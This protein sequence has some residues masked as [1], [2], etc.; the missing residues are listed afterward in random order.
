MKTMDTVRTDEAL[1][2]EY[3]RTASPAALE[4]LVERHWPEA[5]RLALRVLGDSVAAEDTAQEALVWLVRVAKR[6]RPGAPFGPWF[7]TLVLNAARKTLRSRTRRRALEERVA[8][9]LASTR[10]PSEADRRELSA[11]VEERLYQLPEE[12]RSPI[13]LHFM[14]GH[15]HEEVAALVGCPTGT[16]SSR[17]RRGLEQ[18]RASMAR[19]GYAVS[20]VELGQWCTDHGRT[21]VVPP[22]AP[23]VALLEHQA[24]ALAKASLLVTLLV[25]AVAVALVTVGVVAWRGASTKPATEDGSKESAAIAPA[26]ESGQA[27]GAATSPRAAETAPIASDSREQDPPPPPPPPGSEAPERH[28]GDPRTGGAA[29]LRDPGLRVRVIGPDGARVASAA[30]ALRFESADDTRRDAA[31]MAALLDLQGRSKGNTFA[32]ATTGPDGEAWLPTRD[33]DGLPVARLAAAKTK[34]EIA[35]ALAVT[36]RRGLLGGSIAAPSGLG[37]SATAIEVRVA[38]PE[39][40]AEGCGSLVAKVLAPDGRPAAATAVRLVVLPVSYGSMLGIPE[41]ADY[42][43]ALDVETDEDG[44]IVLRDLV[45]DTYPLLFCAKDHAPARAR[46]VVKAGAVSEVSVRLGPAVRI[47]GHVRR[48]GGPLPASISVTCLDATADKAAR[49]TAE[50]MKVMGGLSDARAEIVPAS[51]GSYLVSGLVA[52]SYTLEAEA[53]GFGAVRVTVPVEQGEAIAPDLVLG[54]GAT[55]AGR[56]VSSRGVPL[57][58]ATV[59]LSRKR[60]PFAAVAT[61]ADGTFRLQGLPAG[62]ARLSVSVL[63]PSSP[64]GRILA[65]AG[66]RRRA[67]AVRGIAGATD[68]LEKTIT[69]PEGGTSELGDLVV[70]N[71]NGRVS[72]R[73]VGPD[74][75]PVESAAVTFAGALRIPGRIVTSGPDG[76]FEADLKAGHYAVRISHRSFALAGDVAVEV[77]ADQQVLLADLRV[78]RAATIHGSI[79]GPA[80]R[81]ARITGVV[82]LAADGSPA[83][84]S[85]VHRDGT[86]EIRG[87]APGEYRVSLIGV[88]SAPKAVTV[89]EGARER[90]DFAI[91]GRGEGRILVK[92]TTKDGVRSGFSAGVYTG[93]EIRGIPAATAKSAATDAHAEL[94]HLD[95]GSVTVLVS[96]DGDLGLVLFRSGLSVAAEAPL[97]VSFTLPDPA[98]SGTIEG[99]V[100]GAV[101]RDQVVAIGDGVAVI[102]AQRS[103]GTFTLENVPAGTYRVGPTS[104]GFALVSEHSVTVTVEAGKT[105]AAAIR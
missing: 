5:F 96:P 71:A 92:V 99:T 13:V 77:A 10:R 16:A 3:A 37:E 62:K 73:V 82:A 100:A 57:A 48:E 19:A 89:R 56:V 90:A 52:G 67:A 98:G 84:N 72:G 2:L 80:S 15:S 53:P 74:G 36:A 12:L 97:E 44:C 31:P 87:L 25:P 103:D 88:A 79:S 86:Y 6:F 75:A 49:G 4:E 29:S 102:G 30:V 35:H 18:M 94:A 46:A 61:E 59:T 39:K 7:R 23:S 34:V 101:A 21:A 20:A 24:A 65:E 9:R 43:V 11:D 26:E 17:I 104:S 22:A 8:A 50:M 51:D 78:V 63:E 32:S 64:M 68:A 60:E 45:P 76:R 95:V 33:P 91:A 54:R 28:P 85:F 69:L 58:S 38:G 40:T 41:D 14:E 81:V 70:A 42:G 27:P 83:G 66:S 47:R 1:V 93:G 105:A 55:L